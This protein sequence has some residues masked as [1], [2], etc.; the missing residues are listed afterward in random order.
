MNSKNNFDNEEVALGQFF[1]MLAAFITWIFSSILNVLKSIFSFLISIL[2]FLRRYWIIN[3]TGL[4]I[5]GL[6][7]FI[8]STTEG[9]I[10]KSNLTVKTNFES[11]SQLY[12]RIDYLNSLIKSK[13]YESINEEFNIAENDALKLKKIEVDPIVND[14]EDA[15][16]Y[17]KYLQ[18][19]DTNFYGPI[20]HRKYIESI[21]PSSYR[22]HEI[23]I[24]HE[25]NINPH[26]LSNA[27]T[28]KIATNPFYNL[29]KTEIT[30]R[31]NDEISK[32]DHEFADIDSLKYALNQALKSQK[33]N[34][35]S[36][37]VLSISQK[38]EQPDLS[39]VYSK[40]LDLQ[41]SKNK[42]KNDLT[43]LTKI[44]EIVSPLEEVGIKQAKIKTL[45]KFSF[46]GLLLAIFSIALIR[47]NAF[48]ISRNA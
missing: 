36:D 23:E 5:G 31:L 40:S 2:V 42:L 20:Y 27:L 26:D 14:L 25:K 37:V 16:A 19:V 46:A 22:F 41:N 3:L 24:I 28:G 43:E 4:I 11:G 9:D 6:I 13:N 44:I 38:R 39:W 1:E 18:E 47:L 17:N 45:L 15:I 32:I 34:G 35:M 21:Q 33:S 7:G 48:L 8:L 29:R 12:K 30:K 10:Y